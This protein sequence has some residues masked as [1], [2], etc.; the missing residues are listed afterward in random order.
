[1]EGIVKKVNDIYETVNTIGVNEELELVLR[2]EHQTR[3]KLLK[4]RYDRDVLLEK[5]TYKGILRE[6]ELVKGLEDN[7]TS[8]LVKLVNE[9]KMRL[10]KEYLLKFD[11]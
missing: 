3:L 2:H 9:L 10:Q 1:M 8:R 4:D 11:D 6:I 5:Q 7:H